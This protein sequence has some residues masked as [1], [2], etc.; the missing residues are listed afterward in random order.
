MENQISIHVNFTS[1]KDTRET[2]TI[3]YGVIMLE[4]C[5]GVIHMILLDKFL[6]LFT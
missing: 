4:L 1:S 2:H 3:M 5:E 6:G